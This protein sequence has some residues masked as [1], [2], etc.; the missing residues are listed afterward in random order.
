MKLLCYF[1]L[2]QYAP[3]I[4]TEEYFIAE[5][6]CATINYSADDKPL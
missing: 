5:N 2:H 3:C 1:W 4:A 6:L